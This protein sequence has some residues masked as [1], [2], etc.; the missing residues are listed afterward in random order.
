MK[1]NNILNK[2]TNTVRSVNKN[3][4]CS[5]RKVGVILRGIVGKKVDH[6]IKDLTL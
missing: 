6:A 5:T 3:V 1:K 4:R 2:N